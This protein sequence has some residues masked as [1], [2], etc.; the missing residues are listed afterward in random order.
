MD[1]F[2]IGSMIGGFAQGAL[3]YSSQQKTNENNLRIAR[4][5]NQANAWIADQNNRF[6]ERM[7]NLQN[8]YNTPLAQKQRLLDAGLNPNLMMNGGDTG[9]ANSSVTADQSGVQQL[10]QPMV[11]PQIHGVA[12]GAAA[13]DN[14]LFQR[15]MAKVIS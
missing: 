10:P 1:L 3:N 7:W 14:M 12:E 9:N 2:G 5:T 8:E 11:A 6:N 13:L 15:S 4:E